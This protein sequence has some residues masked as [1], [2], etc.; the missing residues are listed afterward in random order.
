MPAF[1]G[2]FTIDPDASQE[3]LTLAAEILTKGSG[4]VML[5]ELVALRRS[6]TTLC[7]EVIDPDPMARRCVHE[8]E[9]L[10]ENAQRTLNSSG[11]QQHLPALPQKWSVVEDNGTDIL[12]LWQANRVV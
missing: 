4:V 7:C 10:V 9:V 12:E 3:R 11:L 2:A 1:K 8:F 5:E 6:G